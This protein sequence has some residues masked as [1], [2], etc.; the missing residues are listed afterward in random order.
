MSKFKILNEILSSR[1][2]RIFV[3]SAPSGTG[4][5]TLSKKLVKDPDLNCILSVSYTTRK[6]RKGEKDGVDYVF[7]ER[8][9]FEKMI[10]EN[11]FL[12]HAE[13]HGCY[14]GTNQNFV[15]D[16][17]KKGCHVLLD[18][19]VQGA[20][21]IRKAIPTAVLIFIRPPSFE[22]LKERL[23]NRGT[24]DETAINLRLKNAEKEM[25]EV[26]IY[27]HVIV[28]DKFNKAYQ[29]LKRVIQQSF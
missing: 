12:E 17:I 10:L 26:K 8:K 16:Q 15:K 9:K 14:Y 24:E 19:D 2:K 23:R 5:S 13:V 6:P 21:Q 1:Q 25:K 22:S 27:D 18:I 7:I 29:D 28:N 11:Q 20:K 4:K 3:L